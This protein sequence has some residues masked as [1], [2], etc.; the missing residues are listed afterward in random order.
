MG[1]DAD[2][3]SI[4]A[5]SAMLR[6]GDHMSIK[7][8][9][10]EIVS[11]ENVLQAYRD[12]R[13]GDRYGVEW[14]RFW[15]SLEKNIHTLA[16]RMKDLDLPPDTYH[17]FYVYEPKLRKIVSADPMTKVIQRAAYNVLNPLISKGFITDTYSCV[18]GRGQLAAM[19]RLS[20]WTRYVSRDDAKW[21][22]LK[23][24]IE[25]F[26]YRVDHQILM[27]II[28][29]KI[30]DKR[31]VRLLEHYICEAS[32]PFGLPVGISD[33]MEVADED[34]LWDVGITIGGGLSHM[35]GNMYMDPLDQLAKRSFGIKYYIRYMDDIIILSDDKEGL[36]RYRRE[37][38]DFLGDTLRLRLNNRTAIR[39][40]SQG[41]EF[42]GYRIWPSHVRLRKSTSL[43][44]KRRLKALQERY[45]E[46]EVDLDTVRSSV[47]SYKA[48]MKHCD[49]RALEKKI[50]SGFVLT[51]NRKGETD[52]R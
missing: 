13:A 27:Q 50:F 18:K 31:A 7:N 30:G 15:G 47:M 20:G 11:F 2:S 37:F 46:H 17:S 1:M 29:K 8:V 26:F 21:Y 10:P 22:Y 44:M 52:D 24:D 23:M 5:N 9:F 33:P 12:V 3:S 35:Y 45:R 4:P 39:P 34:M 40:V 32:M 6:K 42:V 48:L 19:Q 38:S 14:L 16:G 28:K 43:R 25:K 51:H 49:C 36:N 41:I